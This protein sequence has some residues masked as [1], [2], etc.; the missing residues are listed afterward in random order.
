VSYEVK[1]D[2]GVSADF[3]ALPAE[4][5]HIPEDWR[6]RQDEIAPTIDLAIR[7]IDS[8]R[9]DPFQ[10]ELMAGRPNTQILRGCRCLKFDPREPWPRDR[11][12]RPRVRM[13]L[14]W[15]NEPNEAEVGF[16][17]VLSVTHRFHSRPYR[18]AAARLGAARRKRG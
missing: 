14:V 7:L 2:P 18:R 4:Q 15:I 17:R 9:A 11:G 5:T 12:G 1:A 3:G 13:R 10:G 8:L 6:L 16:V